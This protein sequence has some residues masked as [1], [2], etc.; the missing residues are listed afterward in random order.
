MDDVTPRTRDRRRSQTRGVRRLK[1]LICTVHF[2][3]PDELANCVT[4]TLK[5]ISQVPKLENQFRKFFLKLDSYIH[6][7]FFF[8]NFWLS[9]LVQFI[10]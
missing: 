6:L 5:I 1:S 10:S 4:V 3:F 2:K 9:Q 8:Y 7:Q